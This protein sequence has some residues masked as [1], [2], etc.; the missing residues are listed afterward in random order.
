MRNKLT[1]KLSKQT[2]INKTMY[3]QCGKQ[4]NC[5]HT[6]QDKNESNHTAVIYYEQSELL[7][8]NSVI[9]NAN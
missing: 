2:E 6:E 4:D 3:C 5:Q 1:D 7:R 9:A 8:E